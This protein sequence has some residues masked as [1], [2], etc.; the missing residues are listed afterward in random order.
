MC[1]FKTPVSAVCVVAPGL[2]LLDFSPKQHDGEHQ[3]Q[4]AVGRTGYIVC[5]NTSLLAET[6][7]RMPYPPFLCQPARHGVD[8]ESYTATAAAVEV[9]KGVALPGTSCP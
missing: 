3:D 5:G 7:I 2:G 9:T 4:D 6:S 8:P 1:F